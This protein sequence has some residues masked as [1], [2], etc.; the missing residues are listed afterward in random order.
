MRGLGIPVLLSLAVTGFVPT[1]DQPAVS[2]AVRFH[3][4]HYRVGDPS[5]AMNVVAQKLEG[6][7]VIVPGLGVGVRAGT[8]YLLFDRLNESDPP[9]LLQP[10][11]TRAYASAAAW[12]TA[13]G[14]AV[15]PDDLMRLRVAGALPQAR[16]HHIAFVAD[17]LPSVR[18]TLT[19]AGAAALQTTDDLVLFDA[20]AGVLVEVVRDAERPDAF[21]CPMHPDVRA[22]EAGRC[23]VCAMSL[24]PIPPPKIGEYNLDVSQV[25]GRDGDFDGLMLRVRE[26]DTNGVVTRFAT[27]HEKPFHL[28][29]VSRDL[30]Y[31]AHGHP[32]AAEDGS[33]ALNHRLAPGEY[34]L[35]ADFLPEGG[36]SQMVQKAIVVAGLRGTR[37]SP[38]DDPA[39]PDESNGLEV[40]L[41]TK[42]LA[43]G[44]H[45]CLTFTV[46][47]AKTGAPVLDL[48]PYLGAPAHMLIV[49]GDL[50]DAIHGHPEELATTGPTVSFHP[51]IPA[52]GDYKLW[53]QFQRAGRVSTTSFE[54]TVDR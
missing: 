39:V 51:L 15:K 54:F 3:H 18:Q 50:E 40:R 21:W 10:L 53:V 5:A 29:I 20:G 26:P 16:Y 45:A 35:I 48:Q 17:D 46:T 42:D 2:P 28:F 9:D 1:A 8:E 6:V 44:R 43:A 11:V 25:R 36:T 49:R 23:P 38:A 12:L 22:P 34:M 31:F 30:K 4:I 7:R 27:V 33:L 32:D 14:V 19:S 52:R 41:Q 47:D 37:P 24:V 13:R